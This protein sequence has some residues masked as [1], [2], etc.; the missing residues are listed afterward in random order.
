MFKV[1]DWT[2]PWR[3]FLLEIQQKTHHSLKNI[4]SIREYRALCLKTNET[5]IRP[6]SLSITQSILTHSFVG[7]PSQSKTRKRTQRRGLISEDRIRSQGTSG[8]WRLE[9]STER[10]TR[11]I[12]PAIN[13]SG[14][15]PVVELSLMRT[16]KRLTSLEWKWWIKKG[17]DAHEVDITRQSNRLCAGVVQSR[18]EQTSETA[19]VWSSTTRL[20]SSEHSHSRSYGT[21]QNERDMSIR[22]SSWRSEKKI[23]L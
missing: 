17:G 16:V 7:T 14:N 15:C 23:N 22:I 2:V 18:M 5:N 3:I 12:Q 4:E 6:L 9:A 19:V 21:L 11:Q 13:S 1:K 10:K 20:G 8:S